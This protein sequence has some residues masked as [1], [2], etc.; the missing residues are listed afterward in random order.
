MQKPAILDDGC[1]GVAIEM[2]LSMSVDHRVID[3]VLAAQL[4]QEIVNNLENPIGLLNV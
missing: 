4:L 2:E 1:L 3:G